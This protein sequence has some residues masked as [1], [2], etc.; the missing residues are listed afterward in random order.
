[1]VNAYKRE[2]NEIENFI[3]LPK[4]T[5]SIQRLLGKE[6]NEYAKKNVRWSSEGVAS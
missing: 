1:M 4:N 3:R 2:K 6:E 5:K